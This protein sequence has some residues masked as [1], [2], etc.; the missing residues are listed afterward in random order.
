MEQNRPKESIKI[1]KSHLLNN[2]S[3]SMDQ[4]NIYKPNINSRYDSSE[5]SNIQLSQ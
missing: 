1:K 5:V 2:N 4:S 3:K